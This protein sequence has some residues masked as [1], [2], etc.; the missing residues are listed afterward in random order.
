MNVPLLDLEPQLEGLREEIHA[1]AIK[2]L[3]STR[4]IGGPKVEELEQ[5]VAAYVGA[6]HGVGVSS[7]TDALLVA[8]MALGVGEGDVVL[9]TPY[10]F[11]ATAGVV[12][13]LGATPRFVDIEPSTYNMSLSALAEWFT[14]N[15][16]HADRVKAIIPVHLYGQCADMD[17]I[18]A[19]A[20]V[21]G[22]PVIEDAA[23]AIGASYPSARGERRAGTMSLLGCFSFF[24]SKN[25]G[26]VGD[27][28]LVVTSDG[29]LAE[30][31]RCLR[32]H[33]GRPKYYH[34]M[35]GGNFRLD[36]LQAA[37]LL[38]KLPHLDS[39]HRMRQAN[40]AYY[41]Q[42]LEVEGLVKPAV[43]WGR[44]RHIYNQYVISVPD[45]RDEL[46]A[47]L[48][49]AGVGH[50]VYYPVPFHLQE[51]FQY[52][53]Y[54]RGDFPESEHAAEHTVALPIYPEL[55]REMQDYVIET[56]RAFYE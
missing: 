56:I 43:A 16:A 10:S 15:A 38:V 12:A 6:E 3:D 37:V 30:K 1:A 19:L 5:A 31:L 27:G 9:T 34:A 42:H 51:C 48:N 47:H 4:Y 41:D 54:R 46:R 36:P 40:A 45:R 55:T 22:I 7:G 29:E 50:E 18:S 28:G 23:Q 17:P 26:G 35:I 49:T 20:Q 32:N 44:E 52:L 21:R 2:V 33:G 24:P 14:A 11:F 39:W 25:L 53:D 13:R 8:L